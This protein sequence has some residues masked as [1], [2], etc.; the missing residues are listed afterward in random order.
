MRPYIVKQG[1]HLGRI[2]HAAGVSPEELRDHPLNRELWALRPNPDTLLPGD[3]IHVPERERRLVRL[4]TGA[5][6][7]IVAA[8]PKVD[9]TLTVHDDD[10]EPLAGEPYR[11]EGLGRVVD[12]RTDDSG[13]IVFKAFIHLRSAT[14]TLLERGVVI[15]ARVGD[16]D[17]IEEISGVQARLENLGYRARPGR[18][19]AADRGA[20]LREPVLR[21]QREHELPAT[22]EI[23]Q[24]F[25]DALVAAHGS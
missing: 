24:A 20:A 4:D 12:G 22:G 6:N 9:V 1:D 13:R 16:L 15:E 11:I 18:R 17:P 10:D 23:D 21:F 2:A 7:R 14:V 3:V 25:R 5:T 19:G 8:V